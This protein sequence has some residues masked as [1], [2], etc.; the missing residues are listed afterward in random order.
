MCLRA[1]WLKREAGVRQKRP[2][3]YFATG[4]LLHAVIAYVARAEREGR[5]VEPVQ[6]IEFL[7]AQDGIDPKVI[8]EVER[9]TGAYFAHYGTELAGFADYVLG[10]RRKVEIL[11]VET[12]VEAEIRGPKAWE[13]ATPGEPASIWLRGIPY[14]KTSY[15]YTQRL[16]LILQV[17][18]RVL[19][20]DHKTRSQ[21]VPDDTDEYVRTL[22]TRPQLLGAAWLVSRALRIPVGRVGVLLNEIIKTKIPKFARTEVT[23]SEDQIADW[24]AD[25]LDQAQAMWGMD[26]SAPPPRNLDAC[27][28]VIG[29]QRCQFFDWCHGDQARRD[30][31]YTY[32][33]ARSGEE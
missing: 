9:L 18:D 5:Q 2:A 28:P 10:G 25:M 13:D 30:A 20:V 33:S 8:A 32:P 1:H 29:N 22:Q 27:A 11:G 19:I 3:D 23:F 17:G 7:Y 4:R 6:M 14:G 31:N 16:D 26:L 24:W 15:P 21:K 12:L